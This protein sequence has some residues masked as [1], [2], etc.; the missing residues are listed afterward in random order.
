[1]TCADGPARMVAKPFTADEL[2]AA[3]T[4]AL[5]EAVAAVD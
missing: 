5:H 4:S 2:G 1:M 3:V